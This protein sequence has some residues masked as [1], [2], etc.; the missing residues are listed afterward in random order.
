[1]NAVV[2]REFEDI[3]EKLI[4]FPT[5][6]GT[7]NIEA[8]DWISGYVSSHGMQVER[9]KSG[10]DREIESLYAF[11]PYALKGGVC[12]SGHLDVVPPQKE[13]WK[14]DPYTLSYAEGFYYGRGTSDMKGFIA[15]ILSM[16][17]VWK[18]NRC[19]IPVSI[20]LTYDEEIGCKT[21]SSVVDAMK[22]MQ[23][24]PDSVILGEPT[25]CVPIF[26]HKGGAEC[27][28]T[29][30]GVAGHASNPSGGCSAINEAALYVCSLIEYQQLV[31]QSP[32]PYLNIDPPY[33]TVSVGTIHGGVAR[34]VIPD[35]CTFQ[36]EVRT[37]PGID[38][39]EV[40]LQI[41]EKNNERVREHH[42]DITINTTID[43]SYPGLIPDHNS[44]ALSLVR[45]LGC[46][47]PAETVSFGTEAGYYE[48]S[49]LPVIVWGPG[50][51]KRAHTVNEY[52]EESEIDRY[53]GFLN[54]L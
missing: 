17:P 37:L 40:V 18:E 1:M 20:A 4:S 29:I 7:S 3:L 27:S 10:Y 47:V 30:H 21:V 34:N 35:C 19:S 53:L 5:V 41:E 28:T 22:E 42:G 44:P 31:C 32:D 23:C 12:F 11:F 26:G 39:K 49:G 54:N 14:K 48:T 6:S 16:I 36:W 46:S 15:L 33:T 38:P 13:G 8:L 45:K 52:I 50:S 2:K 24:L 43:D 25:E 51:I 9:V